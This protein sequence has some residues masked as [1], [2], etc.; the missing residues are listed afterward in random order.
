MQNPHFG[1]KIKIPKNVS[2]SILHNFWTCSVQK[3][4]RKNAKYWRNGSISKIGH[5]A[6]AIAHAKSSL[7]VKIKIPKNISKSILQIIYSCSVQKSARKNTK[8]WRNK[9]ILKIRHPAKA[10]PFA[11]CELWVR[12]KIQNNISNL[13]CISFRVVMLKKPLQETLYNSHV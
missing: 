6:K 5:H 4:A 10:I 8:Y 13:F 2:K 9:S 3:T 11:K 7:C 12:I 1:C